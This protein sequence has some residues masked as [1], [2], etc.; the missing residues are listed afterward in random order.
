MQQLEQ[1][2]D[3]WHQA[4]LQCVTASQVNKVLAK[5][6]GATRKSYMDQLIAQILTKCPSSTWTT[7]EIQWG[8]DNEDDAR[9][10]YEQET[11]IFVEETGFHLHPSIE[12]F[13]A[14][15][16]GLANG[17]GLVE[18]KCPNSTTF[19]KFLES[20]SISK[21]YRDQM[22]CQLSCTE[23]KWCDFVM[24]DPRMP[25]ELQI[26]IVRF[27]PTKEEIEEME[28]EVKKFTSEM[29]ER[30]NKIINLQLNHGEL[31]E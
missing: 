30:L 25:Y 21:G 22:T 3:E 1:R 18:I 19:I 7:P 28:T 27:Q 15:P 4:R 13:G 10:R 23:R 6:N 31:Y 20:G 24:F 12:R 2:S 16:D 11:G 17:E 8:I 26:K 5:G 14:S 29:E 9:A